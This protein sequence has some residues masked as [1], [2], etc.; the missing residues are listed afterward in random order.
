MKKV[1]MILA[2]LLIL[3]ACGASDAEQASDASAADVDLTSLSSTMVYAEVYN[4]LCAPEEY[5][6]K[7]VRMAGAFAIYE[8]DER[9]YYACIIADA[10]ACC[11]Q[12]I[13][14]VLE[15]DYS[16]PEDYPELG[17]TI[18]VTGVFDT[19]YEGQYQ[20]VQLIHA[21]ME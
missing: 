2:F 13:E 3:S 15:G 16:Y 20:Y 14:F 21:E 7:T 4:M 1:A 18:T 5:M 12:G 19:Y 10:T 17:T 6:G 9:N 11:S 8:G